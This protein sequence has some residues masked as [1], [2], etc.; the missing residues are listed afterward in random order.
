MSNIKNEYDK[1]I[2]LV[3]G[4]H[5]TELANSSQRLSIF[6]KLTAVVSEVKKKHQAPAPG[7]YMGCLLD[8]VK[9]KA[10]DLEMVYGRE[11]KF[12]NDIIKEHGK[13]DITASSTIYECRVHIPELTGM[14]PWPSMYKII[15]A[16]K[17]PAEVATQVIE[18]EK[19]AK[20]Y[21]K[22]VAAAYPE[23]MKLL[24]YPKFYYF[25]PDKG[26]PPP[27]KMCIVKFSDA[28]PT[29]GLG[30]YVKSLSSNWVELVDKSV[31]GG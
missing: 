6:D 2:D 12:Y 21:P 24:L 3:A 22:K 17:D 14:L 15:D 31:F 5:A 26:A 18:A 7:E 9:R 29:K 11:S 25:D 19:R 23:L 30:I 8:T 16:K 13:S 10:L 27:G 1:N 20:E 4:K 28:I